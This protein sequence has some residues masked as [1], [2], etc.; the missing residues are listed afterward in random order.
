MVPLRPLLQL[1]IICVV[2][3]SLSAPREDHEIPERSS[4]SSCPLA[5]CLV[6]TQQRL[7][8][9]QMQ[10]HTHW[11]RRTLEMAFEVVWANPFVLESVE[12]NEPMPQSP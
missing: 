9:K 6:N 4:M 8:S 7:F 10:A 11:L 1:F 5:P 3:I 12:I 2:A